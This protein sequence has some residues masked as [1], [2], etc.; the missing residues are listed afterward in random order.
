MENNA[1]EILLDVLNYIQRELFNDAKIINI[2]NFTDKDLAYADLKCK[3]KDCI[4][5]NIEYMPTHIAGLPVAVNI[6][7]YVNRHLSET[8]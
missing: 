3:N 1:I 8:I 2:G 4:K 7:C 5:V 6:G